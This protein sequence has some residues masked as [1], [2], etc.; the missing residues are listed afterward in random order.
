[1]YRIIFVLIFLT[2]PIIAQTDRATVTG[3]VSDPSK[4]MIAGAQVT[5]HAVATGLEYRAETNATGAYTVSSLPIGSYTM[6]IVANGFKPLRIDTFALNVGQT[7]TINPIMEVGAVTSEVSVVAASSDLDQAT[8]EI[9]GVIQGSQTQALPVNGRYWASL[10]ALIPGAISSGTGTQDNIRFAGLSQEDN[11]FRFDG[12]DATGIN[13]QFVKEA[14]RLQFPME[15]IQEF[16]ASSAVYSADIGGM[17]G[18]QVSMVSKSGGNSFHGSV[19]EYLRNSAF[20]AR[21]FNAT[22]VSPLKLNNFGVSLG[23]PIVKDKLF[24]FVNYEGIRQTFDKVNTGNVPTD[25][26]RAQVIQKS[27]ALAPLINAYPEGSRPTSDPNALLWFS[28]ASNPTDE[29][30]G[31]FRIDYAA[32]ERT[33]VS[34]RFNTDSYRTTS[35][36]LAENTVTTVSPPNAVVDVQH[37]F[38]PTILNDARIGFNRDNYEDVGDATTPYSVSI[39]GFAGYSLG[40]HSSRVD[41]SYSFIDNATFGYGRHTFKAG[42]E[43]VHL[44]ENKKHPLA[45]QSLSYL[46]EK[47]F[48]N[49]K[50]DSYSY[51]APGVET[52]ARDTRYFGYFLDEIKI[53][54]NLTLNAGLRYEYYGVDYD[55]NG[56]GLVF[57]PFTCGLQYCPPGTSFYEPVTKDFEPRISLAWAPAIFKGK[58]VI[59]TGF[60]INRDP[61]QYG[62]LYAANTNIG[63]NFG[64]TQKNIPGLTYPFTPFLDA[65]AFNVSYSAKDRR[66]D[67]IAV[68]QWTLSIQQEILKDT[69]LEVGYLGSRGTHLLRRDLLLN[70]IDPA[71]GQRPFASLTNSTIGWVTTDGNSNLNALQVGLRRNITTGLLISANYQWSHGLSD[72]S[73]GG[74][75][76]DTPENANCRACEYGATDFDVRHNFTTS[77]VWIVPVG[78]GRRFLSSATPVVNSLLGGWQLSG[79]G[80]ARTGLPANVTLSRSASALPDG[81]N[82]NQRPDIVPGQPL[83][84]S[85]QSAD[86]WLNPNAFTAPANGQWGNAPRNAVRVPGVWQIDV[87]MDKRFALTERIGLSFRA[88]VFNLFNHALIGKPNVKWT[89]PSLGT[90]FGVI[91]SAFTS[92]P[93]GTGTPREIQLG[94]R[95]DF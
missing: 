30:G 27:P 45:L 93:I 79:I 67:D 47:D 10:M 25:A 12:V 24:F 55:K 7:R 64:L 3:T 80:T 1:M 51:Q 73:N 28:T 50:L 88:D 75:E 71:T 16:K 68:D 94:L 37:R 61:G 21:Q 4:A 81:L 85:N 59:R 87:S 41:N 49:N 89:D 42:A 74:G 84:P 86:L 46:S 17:A 83:Y 23:G 32:T 29:D 31:L 77:A 92:S 26:Y 9:G 66:R 8:A 76:S 54:P 15:S 69:V 20:D 11:N 82:G 62:A 52:Q 5:L 13:H 78:K 35:S 6:S 39:T 91:T 72:G 38:S 95:L 57:D 90:N 22:S 53:R 48:I 2:I 40:D 14:A 33:M 65:A 34:V 56:I 58:T 18:G 44:Q 63:L 43:I 70:G 36:A 60:G 19:Y